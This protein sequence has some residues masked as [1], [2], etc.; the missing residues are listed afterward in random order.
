MS[1]DDLREMIARARNAAAKVGPLH[2]MWDVIADAEAILAGCRAILTR[3]RVEEI[4]IE[5]VGRP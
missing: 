2:S 5:F 3:G 1:D 4:L